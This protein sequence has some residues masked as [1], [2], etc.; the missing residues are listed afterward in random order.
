MRNVGAVWRWILGGGLIAVV[1][2]ITASILWHNVRIWRVRRAYRRLPEEV[3]RRVLEL[4]EEAATTRPSVTFLRL[5]AE[6]SCQEHNAA[7]VSHI[8]G[9]PSLERGED[10]P[11]GRSV[12]FL[13]QILLDE[14]G[15]GEP[16]QDRLLT[17]F[18]ISDFEL[19]VTS[20]PRPSMR[21]HASAPGSVA[22]APCVQLLP[23]RY[24][25]EGN[26]ERVTASP[27]ALCEMAPEIANLLG[28]F[29]NDTAGLLSQVLRPGVYGYDLGEPDIA[30]EGGEP[31]LIQ[32][33]HKTMCDACGEP[34]RFLFQFGEGI[35]GLRLADGAVGYVYGCDQHPH[36]CAG[37]LDS[38]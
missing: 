3:K 15:L 20:L 29:S 9:V 28:R 6:I 11:T 24:P 38:H 8:G 18:L 36:Q 2:L 12:R 23:V 10:W 25:M 14:P 13:L 17:V 4:I 32:N 22:P 31:S 27:T 5:G 34:M 7:V 37:F 35:L 19:A 30:Y 33:P 1:S 16:W 26:E 21:R